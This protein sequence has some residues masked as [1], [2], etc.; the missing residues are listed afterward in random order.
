MP[1]SAMVSVGNSGSATRA[2]A[3]QALA[4][5]SGET[6]E[7]ALISPPRVGVGS[8][9]NLHLAQEMA[10]MLAVPPDAPAPQTRTIRRTPQRRLAQDLSKRRIEGAAKARGIDAETARRHLSIEPVRLEEFGDVGPQF[11]ERRLRLGV[12]L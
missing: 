12:T 3:L 5:R 9:Q 8:R 10:D 6:C 1:R 2:A 4:R 7:G 11:V